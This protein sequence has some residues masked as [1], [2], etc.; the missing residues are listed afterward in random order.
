MRLKLNGINVSFGENEVLKNIDFEVNDKDKIAVIGR[1]GSGK[2]TLLKVISGEIEIDSVVGGNAKDKIQKT[3]KFEVGYLKQIAFD[4]DGETLENEVLKVFKSILDLKTRIAEIENTLAEGRT[5]KDINKYDEMLA[6]YDRI[7]GYNYLKE[8][9]LAL[10]KFGFNDSDKQKKLSEFS[11]GQRTKIAL[12]KLLLSK[13]D[14]LI[15]DEPTNHLD[16]TTIKWLEEY[17]ANYPKAIIV[18][19]HDRAFLDRF[20]NIVYEIE[21]HE[22]KKYIGNYSSFAQK[23]AQDYEKQLKAYEAYK[24]EQERLQSLADRFRYKATKAKMAQSKLKQI[25]RMEVVENP[26]GADNKVFSTNIKP[27]VESGNDVMEA[28]EIEIGYDKVLTKISFRVLKGDRIGVVGGNGLGKSTLLKS[29][30]EKTPLLGGKIKFGTNVDIGYFDQQTATNNI[31]D[32]S[33]LDNYLKEFPDDTM[34][35]A[36][37]TLGSFLFSGDDVFKSL[38]ELS[39]GELVRLELC[40]IF[41]K[42]PNFLILD[43]PTNHMDIASKEALEKMLE[44]YEGTL[45]FVSHDRYF[46]NK[47]A[48]SLIVFENGGGKFLKECKYAEYEKTLEKEISDTKEV[49]RAREIK[50]VDVQKPEVKEA[51]VNVYLQNKEKA[52][53][54]ARRKKLERLIDEIE[55]EIAELSERFNDPD[56]CSDYVKVL[57]IQSIIDEKNS[58]LEKYTEEWYNLS[59]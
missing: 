59:E 11:G 29:I 10:K 7:G 20:V 47:I 56:L 18:V 35:E 12:I 15:L 41:K 40:K 44:K 57:E 16:I 50:R 37:T 32:E 42:R 5:H 34:T 51:K 26:L 48:K 28:S 8:Y 21:R 43:E 23:K 14:L 55:R 33:I 36:R 31:S 45:I 19:S 22:I 53:N 27:S 49:G 38:K 52:R 54:E 39:G 6:E 25:E 9:N 58:E 2:S 13:P 30:V 24:D 4:D 46:I 17:L 1:N 3:G